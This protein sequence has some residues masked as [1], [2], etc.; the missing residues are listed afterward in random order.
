MEGTRDGKPRRFTFTLFTR[1]AG[2]TYFYSVAK[3]TKEYQAADGVTR[4]VKIGNEL[5]KMTIRCSGEN[6]F[7][8]EIVYEDTGERTWVKITPMGDD[9][10]EV[11]ANNKEFNGIFERDRR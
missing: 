11:K 10:I 1:V 4:S 3:D 8:R 5:M 6:T 2:D 7:E 9:Y